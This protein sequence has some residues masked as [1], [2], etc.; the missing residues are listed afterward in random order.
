M[1]PFVIKTHF[2]LPASQGGQ[3][4]TSMNAAVGHLRYMVDPERHTSA[5]EELLLPDHLEAGMHAR[6]MVERPG[7]LGGF[8][9]EGKTIPDVSAIA[10]L[11]AGHQGPIW[12]AFVSVTEADARAMGGALL[13]RKAWEDAARRVLP[14]MAQ[15]LGIQPA[16]LDWIAAVHRKEGHPHIHL[17]LWEQTPHRQ[18]GKWAPSELRQI[19]Q[20]W[21]RDLYAPMREHVSAVKTAA[22]Q[23]TVQATKVALDAPHAF[24]PPADREAFRQHLQAV[25]AKLP[26]HGSLR[27]AYLPP[28]VQRAVDAATV[29]LLANVPTIHQAADAYV[30]AAK[31]LGSLYGD[32]AA[33]QAE[34]NARQDLRRRMARAVIDAAKHLDRPLDHPSARAATTSVLWAAWN[35]EMD[36]PMDQDALLDVVDAVRQGRL[37]PAQAVTRLI[38]APLSDPAQAQAE[39]ALEKMAALRQ[40]QIDHAE[41]QSARRAAQSL[42]A[43]LARMARQA[44][45]GVP[46]QL[47][48]I[49]QEQADLARQQA[50]RF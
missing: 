3:G 17:L 29:W 48:E 18:R 21:I 19:K 26:D 8:G 38:S 34:A 4:K 20:A 24:L 28:E 35:A 15:A 12:R 50:A 46:K 41:A 42:A 27:Y 7:S 2:Y 39:R 33:A 25:R 10:K 14:Q 1:R 36:A 45:R 30:T 16:N 5:H 9:P 31:N 49:E 6:Y 40:R 11:F 13:T 47:W 37:T 44:G 32:Q 23:A 43:G 22:R